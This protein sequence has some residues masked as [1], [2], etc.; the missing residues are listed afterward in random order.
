MMA[1]DDRVLGSREFIRRVLSEGEERVK[2]NLRWKESSRFSALLSMARRRKGVEHQKARGGLKIEI[3]GRQ[4]M[5]KNL[6]RINEYIRMKS[7]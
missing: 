1:S 6:D 3:K 2:E 5:I 7:R 4:K